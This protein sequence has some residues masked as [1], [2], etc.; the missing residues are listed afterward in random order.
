MVEGLLAELDVLRAILNL[1]RLGARWC[2]VLVLGLP[3]SSGEREEDYCTTKEL[4]FDEKLQSSPS[5]NAFIFLASA[6]VGS[7]K[8]DH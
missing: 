6:P 4:L 3:H 1:N 5:T 7:L 2:L 8:L